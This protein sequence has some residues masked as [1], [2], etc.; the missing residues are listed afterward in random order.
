MCYEYNILDTELAPPPPLQLRPRACK[1]ASAGPAC[2]CTLHEVLPATDALAR[3]AKA[4]G[5]KG[6]RA[7]RRGG[8]GG[9]GGGGPAP[10]TQPR[11]PRPSHGPCECSWPASGPPAGGMGRRGGPKWA[12]RQGGAAKPG[13]AKRSRSPNEGP[14]DRP[15]GRVSAAGPP[16][17]P[18][19][20]RGSGQQSHAGARQHAPRRCARARASGPLSVQARRARS[21]GR[22]S[23]GA[24]GRRPKALSPC[25][26][27]RA[28][29]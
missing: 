10:E 14:P 20:L 28:A 5:E 19:G 4:P 29:R 23:S 16:T 7:A 27:A 15:M 11:A 17:G 9:A 1:R 21:V 13:G 8:G 24:A 22:R 3:R 2:L 12:S 18:R 6:G 26:F 25:S